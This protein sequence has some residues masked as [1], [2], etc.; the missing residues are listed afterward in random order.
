M[1]ADD[2]LIEDQSSSSIDS[3]TGH[4]NHSHS[5]Q[6]PRS[7]ISPK[8]AQDY[9]LRNGLDSL[10]KDER[11]DARLEGRLRE[12]IMAT[13]HTLHR[14]DARNDRQ[15]RFLLSIDATAVSANPATAPQ[16]L[17]EFSR[18]LNRLFTLSP[19]GESGILWSLDDAKDLNEPVSI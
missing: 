6:V 8:R 12:E 10:E 1:S 3:V 7:L 15:T 4:K 18:L 13:C 16:R 9:L 11:I 19:Q 17:A 2:D 14:L 5:V